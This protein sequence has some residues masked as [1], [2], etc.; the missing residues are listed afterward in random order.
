M[1]LIPSFNN[2]VYGWAAEG[3]GGGWQQRGSMLER[4]AAFWQDHLDFLGWWEMCDRDINHICT[5]L[6]IT[7]YHKP[8]LAAL[9]A[10]RW[11]LS[12]PPQYFQTVSHPL[13]VC[14]EVIKNFNI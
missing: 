13:F 7:I 9:F 11:Q 1:V 12:P 2:S 14:T 5:T 4:K 10:W 8:S 3:R 6:V